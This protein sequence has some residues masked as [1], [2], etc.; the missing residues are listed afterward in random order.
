MCQQSASS[1]LTLPLRQR[2]V[3]FRYVESR[4][5]LRFRLCEA[6]TESTSLPY[7]RQRVHCAL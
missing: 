2:A 7:Q 3:H 6:R 4:Q 5:E 1:R